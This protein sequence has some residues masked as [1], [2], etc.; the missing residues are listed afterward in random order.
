LE[1]L[2]LTTIDVSK[3]FG[4]EGIHIGITEGE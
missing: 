2:V 1:N 4:E 3:V